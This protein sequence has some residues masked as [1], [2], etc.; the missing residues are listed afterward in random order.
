MGGRHRQGTRG[1]GKITFLIVAG[2]LQWNAA[3][4]GGG[5][6]GREDTA[7]A[8]SD[9]SSTTGTGGTANAGSGWG[10]STGGVGGIDCSSD[11][12]CV[13]RLDTL[14]AELR[15]PRALPDRELVDATCGTRPADCPGPSFCQCTY[16]MQSD[17]G[18]VAN[19]VGLGLS[20]CDVY[21]RTGGCLLS[22]NDFSGCSTDEACP[23]FNACSNAIRAMNVDDATAFD[24]E[25]RYAACV[26][27][28]CRVVFRVG[29]QCLAGIADF[30]YAA[31]DCALSDEEILQR[32]FP[33]PD[34]DASSS[35]VC[36]AGVCTTTATASMCSIGVG[37]CT[38][39]WSDA[40]PLTC[41]SADGGG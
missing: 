40:A 41:A 7:S 17:Y 22:S 38:S 8:D 16:T 19:A 10:G 28:V 25:A 30:Q 13:T 1:L 21:S 18:I 27:R 33:P 31:Y 34:L 35:T 12:A 14:L 4:C 26:D 29:D 39:C 32:T 24:P 36:D 9:A 37:V 11:T 20:E 6:A 5:Q 23:C 3:S 15:Q 2:F